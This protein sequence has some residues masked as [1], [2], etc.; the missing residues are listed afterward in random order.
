MEETQWVLQK[1]LAE[2]PGPMSVEWDTFNIGVIE[3]GVF[4]TIYSCYAQTDADFLQ[5]ALR[6]YTS[7]K[8]GNIPGVKV[9]KAVPK[10]TKKRIQITGE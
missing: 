10:R 8:E 6:W 5:G 3:D 2:D 4:R 9:E 1:V 7:F